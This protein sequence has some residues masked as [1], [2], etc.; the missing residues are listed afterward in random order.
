MRQSRLKGLTLAVACALAAAGPARSDENSGAYLAARQAVQLGDFEAASRYFEQALML[1]R[2]NR[3]LLDNTVAS[4]VA[5][6]ELDRAAPL[7]REARDAGMNSQVANLVALAET[8]RAGNWA[9]VQ[10]AFEAGLSVGPLLDGLAQGWALAGM[11]DMSGAEAAFDT[12][13]QAPGL[14]AFGLYH[15]ALAR[16]VA[17][18][19]EG[20]EALLSLS[21]EDGMQR[22]RR[23]V[24]L[25]A[26]VLNRLGRGDEALAM[27]DEAFGTELD[28]SLRSL[29]AALA[30]DTSLPLVIAATPRQG[31]AEAYFS[32]AGAVQG[33][34]DDSYTLLFT[35]MAERLSPGHTEAIL[36]T[37]GL[38]RD[39]ERYNLASAAYR[40]IDTSDPAFHAAELG[41]AEALREA[42]ELEAAAAILDALCETHETPMIRASLGDVE[43][44]LGN[45]ESA[46]AAYSR[47]LDLYDAEHRAR[48]FVHYTRGITYERLG[49]W[50]AAEADFRTAL[51][52]KPGQPQVLNYLGY[53]LVEQDRKLDEALAMIEAAAEAQPE[54]GA[55]ADSLGWVLYRLGRHE[56]AV[57]KL[58]H[59]VQLNPMHAVIIDHLGDA[60]WAVGRQTEARFQWQRA[61]SFAPGAPL[62]ARLREKLADGLE[63]AANENPAEEVQ[64]A[65]GD[66]Q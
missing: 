65:H 14:Q 39:L 56:E 57:A 63:M 59:A 37:A 46:N 50:N 40:Q 34:V 61:L 58:E 51:E 33:Q 18:D 54:N 45:Y 48:W 62:E 27:L 23:S 8:A 47:A 9:G 16:S 6:G 17:G 43:R 21:P 12:V 30:G 4:F 36:R 24:I 28:G 7:A 20:A 11:G 5:I 32:V 38:L 3:Y 25:R 55:I 60:Y 53:S 13:A 35:R 41:R 19:F 29:R 2:S 64:V 26:Q 1:D 66:S 22:T 44:Q 52:L 49:D 10:E 31:L 42:G 15:K